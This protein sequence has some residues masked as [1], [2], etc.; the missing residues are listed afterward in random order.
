MRFHSRRNSSSSIKRQGPRER[1]RQRRV[2]PPSERREPN[3]DN[4]RSGWW[5]RR[6]SSLAAGIAAARSTPLSRRTTLAERKNL[7]TL[8]PGSGGLAAS[9]G[10]TSASKTT[11]KSVTRSR[12]R[13]LVPERTQ[14]NQFAGYNE[15]PSSPAAA[16]ICRSPGASSGNPRSLP[17]G[18]TWGNP[19]GPDS[20]GS[21]L[22]RDQ[23]G[24]PS[25]QRPRANGMGHGETPA[26]PRA[27][28]RLIGDVATEHLHRV[29]KGEPGGYG[30]RCIRGAT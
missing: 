6:P 5:D 12:R 14:R 25:A 24:L 20:V 4:V 18:D 21:G 30:A 28:D 16:T 26:D 3:Q 1:K 15:R 17:A 13:Y 2:V 9:R 7:R 23:P 19:S 27:L 22:D 11:G 10:E 8:R 29:R